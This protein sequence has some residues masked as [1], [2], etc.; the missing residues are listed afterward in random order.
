MIDSSGINENVFYKTFQ[1]EKLP[2]NT[3]KDIFQQYYYYIRTFPQILSGLAPRVDDELI[4]LKICRTVV[5]ELGDG[6]GEPHYIMFEKSLEGIGVKLDDYQ[7]AHYIPEAENLV[8]GLRR[9]F[10]SESPNYAIGAHY[11]IEEFGFPMIANLYE[12]FRLYDG[13]KHED[14][15]YFYLH[16]LI[17]CNHVDWI[18][19]A[20]F[21]AATDETAC[22]EIISGAEQVLAIL[23]D[24]WHGLNQ[25]ALKMAA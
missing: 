12:G 25:L 17:E 13:W 7:K 20:L 19:D 8:N 3:V 1:Q 2:L 21:A 24:F 5:S 22:E 4:R 15:N 23:N 16:I 18:Q 10:L 6:K 9:L 11:V 14:F